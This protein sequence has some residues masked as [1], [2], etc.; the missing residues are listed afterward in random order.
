MPRFPQGEKLPV[1]GIG[2]TVKVIR[3]AICEVSDTAPDDGKNEGA[4]TL[5]KLGSAA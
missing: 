4:Q 3:I 1:D 2:N 5:G